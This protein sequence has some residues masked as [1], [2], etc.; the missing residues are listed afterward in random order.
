VKRIRIGEKD[1]EI[2]VVVVIPPRHGGQV[3]AGQARPDV[4]EQIGPRE[5]Q[6]GIHEVLGPDGPNERQ[7]EMDGKNDESGPTPAHPMSP[8]NLDGL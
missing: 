3:D 2:P 5:R 8:H 4:G 1:I 6:R 7:A